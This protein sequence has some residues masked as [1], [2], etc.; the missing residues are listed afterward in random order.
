MKTISHDTLNP[1]V[2]L[3]EISFVHAALKAQQLKLEQLRGIPFKLGE[4]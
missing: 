4:Q 2:L 3:A 1:L